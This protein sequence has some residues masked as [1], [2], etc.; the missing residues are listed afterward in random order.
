MVLETLLI[1]IIV[2]VLFIELMDIY[3]GGIIVP[4]YI[5]LYL[6][7]PWRVLITIL[8]ALLSLFTYRA[9]SRFLILYGRRRFAMIVFLGVLWSQVWLIILPHLFS[10]SLE[11]RVIG[12]L[13]PGLLA[14]NLE[15]Q[16]FIPTLAAL[17]T[18][19][20]IT[21]FL[22]RMVLWVGL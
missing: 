18:V 21:Y 14:N 16:K 3:P 11:L 8:V 17:F 15:K 7:Q 1:G 12:W 10:S 22:A 2:A 19:A 6:D 20:I 5:A 13:I 9:L 4:G